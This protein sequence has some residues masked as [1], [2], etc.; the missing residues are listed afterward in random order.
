MA[1]NQKGE[2]QKVI[3]SSLY[4]TVFIYITLNKRRQDTYINSMGN[5]IRSMVMLKPLLSQ[6][7]LKDLKF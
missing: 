7:F 2:Y 1:M 4:K 3:N 5:N 6:L